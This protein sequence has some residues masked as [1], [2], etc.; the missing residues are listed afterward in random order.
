MGVKGQRILKNT[1]KQGV[2]VIHGQQK[3]G[4]PIH[5]VPESFIQGLMISHTCEVGEKIEIEG[6]MHIGVVHKSFIQ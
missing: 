4:R 6:V 5:L 1:K 2:Q 3:S